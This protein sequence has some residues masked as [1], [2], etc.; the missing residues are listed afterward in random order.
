M[1]LHDVM[2]TT[3]AAR[4]FTDDDIPDTVIR[5][6]LENARFAPSG[7]IDRVGKSLLSA[8]QKP[9]RNWYHSSNPH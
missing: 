1:E 5:K 7:A 4:E 6:I 8:R 3:F 9:V 2:R